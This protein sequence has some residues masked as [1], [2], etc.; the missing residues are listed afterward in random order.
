MTKLTKSIK[1]EVQT[2]GFVR[3]VIIEIDPETK[4][5]GFRE[6]GRHKIYY[7]PNLTAFYMAVKTDKK[8]K[9]NE[10]TE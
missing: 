4:R 2:H 10:K 8:G 6:K 7:L 3:P 9:E 5:L 1:R